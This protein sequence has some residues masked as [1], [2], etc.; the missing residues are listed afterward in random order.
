[1]AYKPS[2]IEVIS[3][4]NHEHGYLSKGLFSSTTRTS[5]SFPASAS[6]RFIRLQPLLI[7]VK[8]FGRFRTQ[9]PCFQCSPSTSSIFHPP[10]GARMLSQIARTS[11]HRIQRKISAPI[12]LRME[13]KTA[14]NVVVEQLQPKAFVRSSHRSS[15]MGQICAS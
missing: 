8:T 5:G 10:R 15:C 7:R 14:R 2:S 13:I 1:M 12:V 3:A 11:F 6:V 4:L 9:M